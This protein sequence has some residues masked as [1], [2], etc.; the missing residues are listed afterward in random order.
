MKAVKKAFKETDIYVSP[1]LLEEYRNTPLKLVGQGKI[2][3]QQLKVL[4]AGI[5]A[6]VTNA[7]IVY[8]S[9][10]LSVCR[11]P[12]DNILLECCMNA[13]AGV[14]ITSDKDLLETSNLP[15]DLKIITPREFIDRF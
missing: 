11:D 6:F 2:T 10:K 14:L 9:E 15:F 12:G 4:I 1:I 8:P 3:H 7:K 5:A 13:K